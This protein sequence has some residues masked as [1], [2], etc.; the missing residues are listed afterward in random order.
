MKKKLITGVVILITTIAAIFVGVHIC[1][2][3]ISSQVIEDQNKLK[4]LNAESVLSSTVKDDIIYYT[5]DIKAKQKQ[6]ETLH[7][8]GF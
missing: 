6:I 4:E 8:L 2:N 5:N 7:K 1:I 3:L